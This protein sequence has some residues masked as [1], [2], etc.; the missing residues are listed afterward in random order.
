MYTGLCECCSKPRND[1]TQAS[2]RRPPHSVDR[3]QPNR[4]TLLSEPSISNNDADTS[5]P[6]E[7]QFR[8]CAI[9]IAPVTTSHKNIPR[10]IDD[11]LGEACEL[12]K[13]FEV[14]SDIVACFSGC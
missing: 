5:E 8:S 4:F 3:D 1:C 6:A 9:T 12:C 2:N 10:L 14:K 13:N 7:A 11:Q